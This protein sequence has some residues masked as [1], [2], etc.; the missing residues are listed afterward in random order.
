M[1][2]II[3][4]T[5]V[6][7]DNAKPVYIFTW[8]NLTGLSDGRHTVTVWVINE[9]GSSAESSVVFYIDTTPP[10]LQIVSPNNGDYL[11]ISEVTVTWQAYSAVGIAYYDVRWT[12]SRALTPISYSRTSNTFSSVPT[13]STIS[14]WSPMTGAAGPLPP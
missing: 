10:T 9:V 14:R 8:V 2:L 5:P 13:G 4:E 1:N 7:L 12:A 11:N 6:Y 3:S